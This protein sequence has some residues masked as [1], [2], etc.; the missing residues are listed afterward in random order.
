MKRKFHRIMIIIAMVIIP[1]C[2]A[3]AQA[4]YLGIIKA[5]VKKAIKAFDLKVQRL[6][7]ETIWLQN[8]QKTIENQ[9]S[10]L[11]LDEISSW[12]DKQ[13]SLFKDYYQEL[14][15][16]KMII[17]YYQKVKDISKKQ[18]LLISSYSRAWELLKQDKHFTQEELNYMSNVYT[19]IIDESVQNLD[20]VFMV[21]NSFQTSMSDAKRLEIIDKA[22]DE[23]DNNYNDLSRFNSQNFILSLQRARSVDDANT[24]KNIYGLN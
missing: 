21:I 8:A 3:Q 4:G 19:G 22:A 14:T 7:N 2:H 16:V 5:G 20:Q 12:A 15:K 6:Q 1:I 23:I 11:K 9:M 24:I 13:T 17:S 10:K 18:V